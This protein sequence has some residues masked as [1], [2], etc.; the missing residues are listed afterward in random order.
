MHQDHM[1][2]L[3]NA[4]SRG[5]MHAQSAQLYAKLQ[6]LQ[7]PELAVRLAS[8][9]SQVGCNSHV[10]PN[11]TSLV[12]ITPQDLRRSGNFNPAPK[13]HPNPHPHPSRHP[14][15]CLHRIARRSRSSWP[16]LRTKRSRR[17]ANT[18]TR[19]LPSAAATPRSFGRHSRGARRSRQRSRRF[20]RPSRLL[21]SRPP[22]GHLLAATA[23]RLSPHAAPTRRS[24]R[25][26]LSTRLPAAR[27]A[28]GPS[29]PLARARP[30]N[31]PERRQ[32]VRRSQ[33][34]RS[35]PGLI[36]RLPVVWG[37]IAR[38]RART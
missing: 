8:D 4:E 12:I 11:V 13:P 30:P 24:V 14:S 37:V 7:P 9:L 26:H 21:A 10:A 31:R 23:Y 25:S 35:P 22:L 1:A 29:L 38:R 32:P 3:L 17:H 5:R 19:S 33:G 27:H 36:S 15:P 6:E 16:R 18:P 20:G 34:A 28:A 2:D